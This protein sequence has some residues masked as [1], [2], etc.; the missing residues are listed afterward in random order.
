[1]WLFGLQ[2]C[3]LVTLWAVIPVLLLLRYVRFNLCHCRWYTQT[4]N[5]QRTTDGQKAMTMRNDRLTENFIY[6]ISCMFDFI[7]ARLL[8]LFDVVETRLYAITKSVWCRS[9]ATTCVAP[10]TYTRA[11]IQST[12]SWRPTC[13][14]CGLSTC[15]RWSA[16]IVFIRD[17]EEFAPKCYEIWTL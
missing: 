11:A 17:H 13:A 8:N 9:Q 2:K 6:E 7:S 10:A 4:N 1:M 16:G 15:E 3:H 5:R 14:A 12:D